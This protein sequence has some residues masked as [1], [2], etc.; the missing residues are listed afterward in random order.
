MTSTHPPE[1]WQNEGKQIDAQTNNMPILKIQTVQNITINKLDITLPL[2]IS[3]CKHPV[4]LLIDCG[5][6]AS[7]IKSRLLRSN[8]TNKI[9]YGWDQWAQ[10]RN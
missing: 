3:I 9:L 5:S 6:H 2:K 4:I 7:M 8:V 1:T 10:Q